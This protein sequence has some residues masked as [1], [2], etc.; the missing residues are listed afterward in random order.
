MGCA[1]LVT[2]EALSLEDDKVEAPG[3]FPLPRRREREF[4]PRKF[5]T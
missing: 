5:A 3:E 1:A 2:D 4:F